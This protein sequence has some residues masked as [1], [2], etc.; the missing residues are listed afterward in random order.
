MKILTTAQIKEL[1]KRT[2]EEENISS[3]ALMERAATAL[4]NAICLLFKEPRDF[5]V[6]AGPGNNGG[7]ALAVARMLSES[8]HHVE[9]WLF[10]PKGTLSPDCE[11]NAERLFDCPNASFTEVTTHFAPPTLYRTDVVIDGLFGS[12]LNKPLDGGFAHVV[13]YINASPATVVSIDIP[14]GLMGEDNTYNIPAHI[15]RANFTLTLQMPK[16][17]FLFAENQEYIGEWFCLDIGLSRQGIKEAD[18]PYN[19][20]LSRQI[21]PMMK[22]RK[23]FSHKGNYGH[24]LLIAGCYGMAGASVLAAKACLR[25][26]AGRLTVHAPQ[27]NNTILQT[28]VPEA[29]VQHDE[30]EHCFS[31]PISPDSYTAIAIGPGL[32]QRAE[33]AM[34]LHEQLSGTEYPIIID[35]DALNILAA[36]K[37]WFSLIPKESILTPH[38]KELERLVGHCSGSYE[39]LIRACELAKQWQVCIILKGAWSCVITPKGECHFNPTGNPGMATGGS[40]DVLTGILLGL[41]AQGYPPVKTALIGTYLHGVAGDIAAE[42]KGENGMIAS[43]I[44]E[45]L[46]LAWNKLEKNQYLCGSKEQK[47]Y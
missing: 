23:E 36:N 37:N 17:A 27:H 29:M 12:G 9:V 30:H 24:A 22:T 28:A 1:D 8:G 15:I 47:C 16:L 35:A 3:E 20:T 26:G 43:D 13:K 31:T 2:I 11:T 25:S 42:Q 21:L 14:S 4:A 5:K 19:I 40:G 34:A 44:I 32:G 39:R 41:L 33:T 45:K 6:F 10:N 46:P 18:S 38:P 7:D